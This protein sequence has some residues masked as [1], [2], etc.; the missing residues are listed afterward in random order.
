MSFWDDP[1]IKSMGPFTSFEKKAGEFAFKLGAGTINAFDIIKGVGSKIKASAV[2]A[3]PAGIAIGAGK[4]I[5]A[6]LAIEVAAQ[7]V[8]KIT[9]Y[10]SVSPKTNSQDIQKLENKIKDL[11]KDLTKLKD[12]DKELDK[13]IQELKKTNTATSMS[14]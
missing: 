7:A 5:G 1:F 13:S 3:G 11:T 8:S 14:K 6:S 10:E 9:N 2:A 4:M 12:K